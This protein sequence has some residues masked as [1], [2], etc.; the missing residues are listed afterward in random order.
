[1]LP[2]CLTGALAR[3]GEAAVRTAGPPSLR[4]ELDAAK[5]GLLG[6]AELERLCAE[7]DRFAAALGG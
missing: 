3:A 4:E 5:A 6:D 1:M 2:A 7:V